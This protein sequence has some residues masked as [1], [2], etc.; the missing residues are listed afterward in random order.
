MRTVIILIGLSLLFVSSHRELLPTLKS[1][2][3]QQS[4]Y[5]VSSRHASGRARGLIKT[6][7]PVSIPDAGFTSVDAA[8]LHA[9]LNYNEDSIAT[10]REH[11]GGV[12]KCRD[13]RFIYT[14]GHGR[15]NQAPV[16]FAITQT[17]TCRVVA[18]WHTH[19]KFGH[20]KSMFSPSD[21]QSANQMDKPIY[22]ADH[23]GTIRVYEPG[24]PLIM[25][26]KTRAGSFQG[27]LRGSAIGVVVFDPT[28][29]STMDR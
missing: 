8:V 3:A 25:S 12:L 2:S 7:I 22:M 1:D 18:L 24:A 26:S 23:T 21:T 28:L 9:V 17:K 14:Q 27:I 4:S 16:Q 15:H 6:T 5:L 29:A 19:G 13:G 20:H 10:N 11:V